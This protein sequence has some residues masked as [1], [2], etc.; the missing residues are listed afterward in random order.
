MSKR[1]YDSESD[2]SGLSDAL[3][4]KVKIEDPEQQYDLL[5]K[6][7]KKLYKKE[8]KS[9]KEECDK[10]GSKR[11]VGLRNRKYISDWIHEYGDNP[12]R[13]C[14]RGVEGVECK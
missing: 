14:C 11:I 10:A 8:L 6:E 9:F 4:K 12:Q 7:F 3:N 13:G 5:T 1:Q 2:D